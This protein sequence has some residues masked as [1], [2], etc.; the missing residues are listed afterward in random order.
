MFSVL[1]RL[2]IKTCISNGS[3]SLIKNESPSKL[4]LPASITSIE[5]S[6]SGSASS[7]VVIKTLESLMDESDAAVTVMVID[8]SCPSDTESCGV[9]V[10]FIVL[11]SPASSIKSV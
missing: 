2:V 3:L 11:L 4:S 9:I 10:T 1:P 6:Q 8:N 7:A 5:K